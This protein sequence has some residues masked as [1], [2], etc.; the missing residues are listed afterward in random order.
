MHHGAHQ[1]SSHLIEI[2]GFRRGEKVGR[3]ASNS[4]QA[5][6]SLF[7]IS[8]AKM[9]GVKTGNIHWEQRKKEK[10]GEGQR[11][12][13][14]ERLVLKPPHFSSLQLGRKLHLLSLKSQGKS[15]QREKKAANSVQK[16]AWF[17]WGI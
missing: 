7:I 6:G 16:D 13:R 2:V 15:Q 5:A 4:Q 12:K 14:N 1:S 10:L 3:A 11:N 9:V 17:F 8:L